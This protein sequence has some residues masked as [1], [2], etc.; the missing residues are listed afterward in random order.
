M[1]RGGDAAQDAL[2]HGH[3][4]AEAIVEDLRPGLVVVGRGGVGAA[5][6]AAPRRRSPAGVESACAVVPAADYG[7]TSGSAG[8]NP[9]ACGPHG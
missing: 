1:S 2:E 5:A 8:P 6:P 7:A 9:S 4:M 3:R